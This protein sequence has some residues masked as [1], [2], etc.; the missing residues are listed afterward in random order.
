MKVRFFRN[1]SLLFL[2]SVIY[3]QR[4]WWSG[5]LFKWRGQN[6]QIG[7]RSN[8]TVS[9]SW[10]RNRTRAFYNYIY[11][12]IERECGEESGIG[13]S[14]RQQ[15]LKSIFFHYLNS[16]SLLGFQLPLR[17]PGAG[18]TWTNKTQRLSIR[19]GSIKNFLQA[20]LS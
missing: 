2:E 8:G 7:K 17:R 18:E 10:R 20:N 13:T 4:E 9:Y 16:T 12:Y 19:S 11:L 14:Q 1:I 5:Q 6:S 3:L 15:Y